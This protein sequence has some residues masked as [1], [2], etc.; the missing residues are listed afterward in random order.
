LGKHHPWKPL[1]F[2]PN[3]ASVE[4]PI[5][6]GARRPHGRPFRAIEHSELDAGSIGGAPHH[7]PKRIH[8]SHHGAFGDPPDGGIAGHLTDGLKV[9]CEQ[10]GLRAAPRRHGGGFRSGV[11][12]ADDYHIVT[13]HGCNLGGEPQRAED[14]ARPLWQFQ[15]RFSILAPMAYQI[16]IDRGLC[17]SYAECEAIAPEV[18][19]L[20]RDKISTLVDPQGADDETILD[21]ARACPVDAII[22]VDEYEDRVWPA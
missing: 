21:A 2:S 16:T 6:L 15:G 10:E 3:G 13:S 8:L 1:E 14:R 7:S 19:Q 12:A 9:L 4:S 17:S 18:F 22:L 11:P 20:G 5:A